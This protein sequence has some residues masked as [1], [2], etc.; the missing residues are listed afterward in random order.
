[1]RDLL[2]RNKNQLKIEKQE[3]NL[4]IIIVRDK[5]RLIDRIRGTYEIP[6]NE[7]GKARGRDYYDSVF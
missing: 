3:G 6:T 1:M 5:Q 2:Q 7:K 4:V